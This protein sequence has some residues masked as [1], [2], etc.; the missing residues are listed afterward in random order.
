MAAAHQILLTWLRAVPK[1]M[2]SKRG[3]VCERESDK[4]R[5]QPSKQCRKK[6][7]AAHK[8]NCSREG[9]RGGRV[10]QRGRKEGEGRRQ[11]NE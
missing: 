11:V 4:Q 6:S 10:K 8:L 2:E 1:D 9:R 5:R 3:R 7:L